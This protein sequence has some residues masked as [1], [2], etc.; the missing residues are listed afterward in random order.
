MQSILITFDSNSLHQLILVSICSTRETGHMAWGKIC[1]ITSRNISD[2]VCP[3]DFDGRRE[4]SSLSLKTVVVHRSITSL[5]IEANLRKGG[6]VHLVPYTK[7]REKLQ[8]LF[9][10]VYVLFCKY[11]LC[12]LF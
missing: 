12:N 9:Q 3:V 6:L 4:M 1:T 11:K 5:M 7:S 2:R 10:S 8:E